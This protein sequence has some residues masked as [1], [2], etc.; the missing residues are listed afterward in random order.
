MAT[1]VYLIVVQAEGV[2]YVLALQSKD[3]GPIEVDAFPLGIKG[4]M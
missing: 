1:T 4:R 3:I 2:H